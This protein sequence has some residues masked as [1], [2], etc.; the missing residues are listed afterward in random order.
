[1]TFVEAAIEILKQNNNQPMSAREIWTKISEQNLVSTTGKTPQATLNSYLLWHSKPEYKKTIYFDI[2]SKS[3]LK[4][5]IHDV[6]KFKTELINQNDDVENEIKNNKI[7]L[8]QI[9]C[10]EIDWKKLNIYNN[11]NFIEYEITDCEEYTYIIEDKAHATIKIGK[12]KNDPE[13]RLSQL[14]TGNPTLNLIHVFPSCLFSES[15]L[16]KK[17]NDYQKDLE[18]FFYTKGLR[19]FLSDEIKK[20]NKIINWYHNKIKIDEIENDMLS[21]F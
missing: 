17:F 4:V 15:E 6:V 7:L 10:K 18:W 16:H 19:E 3:P 11:N 8:Y 5:C 1:M 9:T 20:H 2:C 13:I 21:I 14:K 12:T